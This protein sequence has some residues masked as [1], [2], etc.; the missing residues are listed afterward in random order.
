MSS[1]YD[2]L[3]SLSV[4]RAFLWPAVRGPAA[5]PATRTH[6]GYHV[7]HWTTADYTYWV[8]SD[9]GLPELGDFA[10]L[11]RQADSAAGAPE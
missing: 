9:L 4:R 8:V 7:L 11:L 10:G 5:A 2:D 3:L 1:R 6:Q